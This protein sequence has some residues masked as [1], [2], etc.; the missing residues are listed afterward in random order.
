MEEIVKELLAQNAKLTEQIVELSKLIANRPV[1]APT[2]EPQAEWVPYPLHIPEDEEDAKYLRDIG[3]IDK[4]EYE[5]I[6]K[7]AGLQNTEIEIALP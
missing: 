7:D 3:A 2:S 6:L 1:E 4:S 5:Q